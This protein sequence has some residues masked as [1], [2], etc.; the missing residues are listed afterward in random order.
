MSWHTG[1]LNF[2]NEPLLQVV[3]I[4]EEYLFIEI[5]VPKSAQ[6]L[7]YSGKF[8]SPSANDVAEVLAKALGYNYTL[9]DKKL[10]FVE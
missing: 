10:T 3:N 4:L 5:V 6:K 2:N 7:H 8:N 9:T 1:E